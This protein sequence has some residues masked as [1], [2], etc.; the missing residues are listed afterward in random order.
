MSHCILLIQGINQ[1]LSL[2]ETLGRIEGLRRGEI[3]SRFLKPLGRRRGVER[4]VTVG[5]GAL[6]Q[7]S[8]RLNAYMENIA[9]LEAWKT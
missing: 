8:Q 3:Q 2:E 4:K 9:W 5:D 7:H 1:S 6:R